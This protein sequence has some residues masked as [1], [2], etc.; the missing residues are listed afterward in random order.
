MPYCPNCGCP[1]VGNICERCGWNAAQIPNQPV[2]QP[3]R[4]QQPQPQ[5]PGI[6]RKSR[7]PIVI[8]AIIVVAIII[9]ALMFFLVLSPKDEDIKEMTMQEFLDDYEDSNG[10]GDIDNLKSFNSGD[11][12]RISDEV[13]DLEYDEEADMTLIICES[14]KDMEPSLPIVLDG[15]QTDRY[16]I[17]DPISVTWHI[18]KYTIDGK[19]IEIP[20]EFYSYIMVSGSISNTTTTPTAALDF[21]ETS[22]GNFT[23]GI[24]ALSDEVK[25]TDA[26]ITIIDVSDGSSASQGP[27]LQSGIPITTLG[28]LSLKFTDTNGN[29]KMDA[30]D[31][32]II[33]NG[34]YG[35][36]IKWVHENGKMIAQYTL[37]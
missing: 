27:P 12:V 5:Y 31:V 25:L 16:E 20:Q 35:D 3:Q 26:S 18:K 13:A 33:N 24:L 23:G 22:P 36:Q 2:Q 37:S 7:A 4:Y 8:G 28:G 10:D 1:I 6:Q 14:A 11:K 30:G 34:E 29:N 21:T 9:F 17:G 15:D 19:S 32:W